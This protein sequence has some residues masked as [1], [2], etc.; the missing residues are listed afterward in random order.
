MIPANTTLVQVI[1]EYD[2]EYFDNQAIKIDKKRKPG[3]NV[4]PAKELTLYRTY[5][6]LILMIS[7]DSIGLLKNTPPAWLTFVLF[8]LSWMTKIMIMGLWS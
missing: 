1:A 3:L 4:D 6:R 5:G 7:Y 8:F 2:G